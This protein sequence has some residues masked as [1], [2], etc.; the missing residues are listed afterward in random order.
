MTVRSSDQVTQ[1]NII[2][3]GCF[4]LGVF[5]GPSLLSDTS[6]RVLLVG[7]GFA[8]ASVL[9]TV[10]LLVNGLSASG[11]SVQRINLLHEKI[12]WMIQR[13]FRIL[14]GVGL[15]VLGLILA[16]VDIKISPVALPFQLQPLEI[17]E[18]LQRGGVGLTIAA[19]VYVLIGIS[20][21]PRAIFESL[22]LR[23]EIAI[24]EARQKNA[25][26]IKGVVPKEVFGTSPGFGER[27]KLDVKVQ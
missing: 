6:G 19:V 11:R 17:S 8:A 21:I 12:R 14:A 25:E 22:E 13:L 4:L 16:S 3:T 23:K 26:R 7:L 9:P 1:L 10:T 24:E 2:M 27:V 18:A 5:A 20:L 15:A